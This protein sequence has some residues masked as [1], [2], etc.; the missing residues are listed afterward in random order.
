MKIFIDKREVKLLEKVNELLPLYK[1]ENVEIIPVLLD[2]GDILVKNEEEDMLLI[3]RKTIPDLLASIKDGRYAEQ[4]LRLYNNS[5]PNNNIVY[6]L[7]GIVP[8]QYK[9]IIYST[10][11]SLN[12]FKGFSIMKTNSIDETADWLLIMVDKINRSKKNNKKPFANENVTYCDV[13]KTI[14]K[15]N[16]NKENIGEIMLMQIPGISAIMAKAILNK[17]N[18]FHDFILKINENPSCLDGMTYESSGKQRKIN[19]N[20]I[21]SIKEYLANI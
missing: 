5:L 10:L 8:S 12:V 9:N 17:F 18:N 21:E 6:L 11:T 19:K 7:E 1:F 20:C 2:L 14:K 4:S 13:I 16:I 3:E 15:D